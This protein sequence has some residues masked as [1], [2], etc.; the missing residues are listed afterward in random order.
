MAIQ[1][2]VESKHTFIQQEQ[3]EKGRW[4]KKEVDQD[5][6]T[7]HFLRLIAN[8]QVACSIDF[9]VHRGMKK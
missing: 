5:S 2:V 3:K 8:W 4:R 9:A 7:R 1:K 6:F